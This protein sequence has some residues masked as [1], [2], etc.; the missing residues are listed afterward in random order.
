[1]SIT[2]SPATDFNTFCRVASWKCSERL[3]L[4]FAFH[5]SGGVLLFTQFDH[6]VSSKD[7]RGM[8]TRAQGSW[9][10]FFVSSSWYAFTLEAFDAGLM[11]SSCTS[12]RRDAADLRT[13]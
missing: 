6:G 12:Q 9:R 7:T 4:L 13:Q 1:M 10:T 11:R 8:S 2:S 5:Q 3:T